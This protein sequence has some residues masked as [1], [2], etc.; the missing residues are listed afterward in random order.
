MGTIIISLDAEL[1][2]GFHDINEPPTT[3][4]DHARDGWH[5][6]LDLL[7]EFEIP[8]T[9][10]IVGH[11]FLDECDGT[12]DNFASPNGWFSRDPG[13][14]ADEANDWFGPDLVRAVRDSNVDHEIGSHTFSHVEFGDPSTTRDIADSELRESVNSAEEWGLELDSFVFPRNIVGHRDLLAEHGFICYRG[15][16]PSRW[17]DG[18]PV[19]PLGRVGSMIWGTPPIVTPQI[20]EHGLVNIPASL[21]LFTFDQPLGPLTDFTLGDV[22]V[23]KAKRGIDNAA[24]NDGVFHMWLHPNNL[25]HSRDVYRI[26]KIL[27]YLDKRRSSTNLDVRTMRQVA[28][29]VIRS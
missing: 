13:G 8:A 25:T 2:W 12:H 3:R 28:T 19:Y 15:T 1:A 23:R 20:D 10:A 4:I 26:Q 22:I 16:E 9:W 17:Y 18:S 29:E 27:Q 5:Q 24:I 14:K 21:Y 7:D 6:L 11:L